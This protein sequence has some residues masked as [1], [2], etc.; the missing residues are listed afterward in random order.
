[1]SNQ[2]PQPIVKR[3]RWRPWQILC[4]VALLLIVGFYC[5]STIRQAQAEARLRALIS[6]I[7]KT[8]P[9][10]KLSDL[11]AEYH[12]LL[13][14]PLF[15]RCVAAVPPGYRGWAGDDI[16]TRAGALDYH[17]EGRD[18]NVRFPDEYFKI[19]KE[20]ITD[21]NVLP[22][23]Q[24]LL[25]LA[26]EP[27][28]YRLPEDKRKTLNH[29]QDAR[30]V[31]NKIYDESIYAALTGDGD[32]VITAFQMAMNNARLL[33]QRPGVLDLLVAS[34]LRHLGLTNV[35]KALALSSLT[36]PQLKRLQSILNQQTAATVDQ[37]LKCC[38]ANFFDEWESAKTDSQKR[39]DF[40]K[41]YTNPPD[42][43]GTWKEYV[44][45][46]IDRIRFEFV[47]GSLTTT[48][49][50]L[51]E[52]TNQ[53]LALN[54]TKP[55]QLLPYLQQQKLNSNNV[56][57]KNSLDFSEKL[58]SVHIRYQALVVSLRAALACER[59]RLAQGKW[60][61]SLDVLVPQYLPVVPLDPFSGQPLLYRQLPD[62]V[63]I[64]S[65]GDNRVDDQGDVLEITGTP[66][67]R[68]TRL[69]N[70]ELRGKSYETK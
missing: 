20:R 25:E 14:S 40:I 29:F 54:A 57:L 22:M 11:E 58:V 69:F 26:Q 41:V 65:V 2:N 67:D 51:L 17:P 12:K 10:W 64:Y 1:M 44:Q 15:L 39:S 68:G 32:H 46:W 3:R 27:E 21:V 61:A 56:L 63:V 36:E 43:N 48:Q 50:E 6:E 13:I 23:R 42:S 9:L 16:T 34:P 28:G 38:R 53:A 24:A 31:A 45:Y 35:N 59:Y 62:G 30:V 47:L 66:K 37:V 8:D 4:L 49:A 55:S 5:Y 33:E 18:Y 70:P 60:P 7:E 19:L 52:I